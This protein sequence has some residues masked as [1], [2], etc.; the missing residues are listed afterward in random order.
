MGPSSRKDQQDV[1]VVP[2]GDCQTLVTLEN[3]FAPLGFHFPLHEMKC[4][5]RDFLKFFEAPVI[6]Q[7]F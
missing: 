3:H 4:P 5:S 6:S 1:V 7:Q 2:W